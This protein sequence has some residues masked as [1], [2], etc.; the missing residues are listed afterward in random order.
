MIDGHFKDKLDRQ[1]NRLAPALAATGL[2]ANGVTWLGLILMAV[3][4]ATYP[5]YGLPWVF[6]LLILAIFAFDSLDGAVARYLGSSSKYGG[7]L[8]AMVDRYQEALALAALAYVHDAWGAA[9]FAMSGAFLI[10]Y[11]KA[12]CAIEIEID[13]IDWPD[14]MERLERT[15]LLGLGLIVLSFVPWPADWPVQAVSALLLVLGVLNHASAVQRFLRARGR[16]RVS[17]RGTDQ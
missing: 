17:D 2:D 13:N 9:F 1:W 4:A 12:R 5:L 11:A 15:L 14:L 10:S 7:Y 6:G 16:L 8:D 3:A